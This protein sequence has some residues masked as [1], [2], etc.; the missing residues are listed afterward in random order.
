MTSGRCEI[1]NFSYDDI[2][3]PDEAQEVTEPGD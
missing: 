3:S 1:C 2:I